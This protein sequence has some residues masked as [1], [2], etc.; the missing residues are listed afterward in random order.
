MRELGVTLA[1]IAASFALVASTAEAA[2]TS[3]KEGRKFSRKYV[4]QFSG[5]D[6]PDLGWKIGDCWRIG[7]EGAGAYRLFPRG[8]LCLYSSTRDTTG[9]PCWVLGIAV[10][11]GR[12]Y[13]QASHVGSIQPW[14]G[15][16]AY[17][18]QG[19]GSPELP[20][21]PSWGVTGNPLRLAPTFAAPPDRASASA[22]RARS[23]STVCCG[24]SGS[25][26]G[27]RVAAMS[28]AGR[29]SGS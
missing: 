14:R 23:G 13:M 18:A 11:D 10:K 28:H 2:K 1:L 8:V 15:D 21:H 22:L 20:P 9:Y 24:R 27:R 19:P 7:R 29:R 25:P 12:R 6:F 17:C 3:E 5:R 16:P 4:K 26:A